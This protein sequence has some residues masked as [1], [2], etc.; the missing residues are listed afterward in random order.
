M[1]Q[2]FSVIGPSVFMDA[3]G[4]LY[5]KAND[6][7]VPIRNKYTVAEDRFVEKNLEKKGWDS[8]CQKAF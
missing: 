6:E 8:Q 1:S 3:R 2:T 7:Y 5:K 4:R